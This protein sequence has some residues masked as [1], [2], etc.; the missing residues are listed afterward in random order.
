VNLHHIEKLTVA[1]QP[2]EEARGGQAREARPGNNRTSG[3]A[4]QWDA[5]HARRAVCE[6]AHHAKDVCVMPE[7]DLCPCLV[8]GYG[9]WSAEC[10]IGSHQRDDVQNANGES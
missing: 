6:A 2:P 3:E 9:K 7:L 4:V 1:A 10:P 8:H 5:A